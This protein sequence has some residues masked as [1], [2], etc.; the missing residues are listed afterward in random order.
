MP[1]PAAE[2]RVA[3]EGGEFAKELAGAGEA[4]CVPLTDGEGHDDGAG[5]LGEQRAGSS[6]RKNGNAI[7]PQSLKARALASKRV[8]AFHM[9]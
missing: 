9:R 1:K 7:V 6:A 5:I 3:V 8:G 4:D 2:S